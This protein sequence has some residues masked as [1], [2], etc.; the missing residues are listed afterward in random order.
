MVLRTPDGGSTLVQKLDLGAPAVC[1][2]QLSACPIWPRSSLACWP[3]AL[4]L[5]SI[6][7]KEHS[8]AVACMLE[9]RHSWHWHLRGSS[10]ATTSALHQTPTLGYEPRSLLL[11]AGQG[12]AVTSH[13]RPLGRWQDE[14]AARGRGAVDRRAW[15]GTI[16]L[17][18]SC[19]KSCSVAGLWAAGRNMMRH[20][21]FKTQQL[22]RMSCCKACL[23]D[24]LWTAGCGMVRRAGCYLLNSSNLPECRALECS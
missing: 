24:G 10:C 23:A 16:L 17:T 6:C 22:P 14:H 18:L 12:G 20:T 21:S 9:V 2:R 15:H 1:T 3:L 19:M 13:R 7:I 4:S 5:R 8:P 11:V